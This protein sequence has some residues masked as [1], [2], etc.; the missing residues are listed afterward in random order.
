M[1]RPLC[2]A[3]CLLFAN[4]SLG[5]EPAVQLLLPSRT[6]EAKST[7]EL[8]FAAE[9]VPPDQIGKMA[10]PS[11]VVFDPPIEGRF[12]WLSTRS[13]SFAPAGILPLGTKFKIAVRPGLKDAAGKPINAQLRETA[14]TPPMRVKGTVATTYVDT[15]NA[16]AMPRYSVLFNANVKAATAAKFIRYVNAAGTRIDARVEQIEDPT[17]RDRGYA[18]WNSDDKSLA[19]WGELPE[20]EPA[21]SEEDEDGEASTDLPGAKPK[22]ARQNILYVAP[23]KP[24]PPGKDW[25]LVFEAG[26]P[27]TEWNA[28]LAAAKEIPIGVVQPFAVKEVHAETNRV[29][30]RRLLIAATK[31]IGQEV[32]AENISQ[33]L[34][35]EPAVPNLK[36]II[37]D[38]VITVRGEFALGTRYRVS[39]APGFPARDPVVTAAAFKQEVG[40]EKVAPRLYFQEFTTHQHAAGTRQLR[41][42][43]MNVPRVRVSA[44]LFKGD[45]IP[46]ATKAFA[47]YMKEPEDAPGDEFYSKVAPESLPGEVIWEKEIT[48]PATVDKDETIALSWD[49]MVGPESHWRRCSSRRNRSTRCCRR[50][51]SAHRRSCNSPTS[52]RPGSA[53]R[54][55]HGCI[56]SRSP[57]ARACRVRA[58]DCCSDDTTPRGRSGHGREG[59]RAASRRRKD[60]L[61]A[62][63]ARGG[64]A[65]HP[66]P[67]RRGQHPAL[68]ARH[69]RPRARRTR[70]RARSAPCFSSPNAA[71]TSRARPCT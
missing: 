55:A 36:P 62:G 31:S 53:T 2:C 63:G 70:I 19:I 60:A 29:E 33:W 12:V 32:T 16:T 47:D 4:L 14:E 45:A 49:E 17:Q 54:K 48:N 71:S 24:L 10:E 11:P 26:L 9:M 43:A 37:S 6:L 34:K 22:V 67:Q 1:L 42:V 28:K 41:L 18:K 8:R 44:K 52:A 68:S 5:A 23:A 56:S 64:C 51:A 30:G 7:F 58:C 46:A 3:L 57:A 69:Q 20:D 35:V 66:D 40:F 39:V 15:D 38:S 27:A 50:N 65:P 13:G 59:R 21:P 25:K 61:G